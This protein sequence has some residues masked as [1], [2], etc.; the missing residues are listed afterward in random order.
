M[1]TVPINA[2]SIRVRVGR[3]TKLT[4]DIQKLALDDEISYVA[5]WE[6]S[7]QGDFEPSGKSPFVSLDLGDAE[8]AAVGLTN[9]SRSIR[10]VASDVEPGSVTVDVSIVPTD[11]D[12][13]TAWTRPNLNTAI[14]T[15]AMDS[16]D[17][18]P[19]AATGQIQ[20]DV[21]ESNRQVE[22]SMRPAFR[23]PDPVQA[24]QTAIRASGAAL[25]FDRYDKFMTTLFGTGVGRQA[26]GYISVNDRIRLPFPDADAYR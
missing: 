22:V 2:E 18:W 25:S 7:G 12:K 9:Q 19:I 15:L 24:L 5:I 11:K 6:S 14:Q 10:W 1:A 8:I 20:L 21:F 17:D 23:D 26:A 13:A 4:L 16:K 3:G